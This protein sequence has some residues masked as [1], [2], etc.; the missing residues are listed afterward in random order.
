MICEHPCGLKDEEFRYDESPKQ[1]R[2]KKMLL[3][4][5]YSWPIALFRLNYYHKGF[6]LFAFDCTRTG[7]KWLPVAIFLKWTLMDYH[8][9]ER[10]C[11]NLISN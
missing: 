10:L 4:I 5:F 11:Y 8:G 7:L 6:K 3:Y 9:L 2:L 1:D